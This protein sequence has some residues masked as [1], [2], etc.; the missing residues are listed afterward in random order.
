MS[1]HKV[2]QQTLQERVP[3]LALGRLRPVLDLR[4][5]L[6]VDP[7]GLLIPLQLPLAP[8]MFLPIWIE[9]ALL[10]AVDR[11]QLGGSR[12]EQRIPLLGGLGQLIAAVSTFS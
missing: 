12:E 7:G 11:L 1:R 9:D 8:M 3:R 2:L 4:Q 6:R 5:Q 10:I